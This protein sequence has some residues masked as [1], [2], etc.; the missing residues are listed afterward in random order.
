[1]KK[2]YT[3]YTKRIAY[4]L[5]MMGCKLLR[6]GINQHHPEFLTYIFED[7]DKFQE[8]LAICQKRK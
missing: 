7:D 8:A 6:T 1:M 5:R 3:I 4:E 2:E